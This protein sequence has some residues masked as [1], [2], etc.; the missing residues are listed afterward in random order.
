MR[1]FLRDNGLSLGFGS[2]LVLALTGQA[3][4]GHTEFN[5]Q[6]ATDGLARIGFGA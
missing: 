4:A 3:I 5:D 2:V 6:L 1:R